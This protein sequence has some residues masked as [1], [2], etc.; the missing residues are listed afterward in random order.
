MKLNITRIIQRRLGLGRFACAACLFMASHIG[1]AGELLTEYDFES[2]ADFLPGW[3]LGCGGTY[4]PAASWKTPVKVA[5]DLNGAHFGDKGIK[6]EVVAPVDG[7]AVLCS[8]VLPAPDGDSVRVRLRFYYRADEFAEA[9]SFAVLA[10]RADGSP[11]YLDGKKTLASLI[12]TS[13]WTAV[14]YEGTVEA[15]TASLQLQWAVGSRGGTGTLWLDDIAVEFF[16][17]K[18]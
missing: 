7:A 15:Q 5:L 6:V 9:G 4:K 2:L 18:R 17:T 8:P 10:R 12:P 14:E 13:D 11:R 1:H 3:S 16:Q